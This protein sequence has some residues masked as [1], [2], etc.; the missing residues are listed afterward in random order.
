MKAWTHI[1][2]IVISTEDME[3]ILA[4]VGSHLGECCISISWFFLGNA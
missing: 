1:E 3:I 4:I 2:Y